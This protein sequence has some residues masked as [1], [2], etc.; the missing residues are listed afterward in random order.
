MFDTL[1]TNNNWLNKVFRNAPIRHYAL[2]G[3]GG[4]ENGNFYLHTTF[5]KPGMYRGWIQFQSEGKV[6]TADFVF[7]VAKGSGK[8]K[9]ASGRPV[10]ALVDYVLSNE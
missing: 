2:T 8:E 1:L 9:G 6:H 3:I 5:E 7:K 10:A 4:S